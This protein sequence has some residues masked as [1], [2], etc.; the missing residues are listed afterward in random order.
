MKEIILIV[1]RVR[2]MHNVGSFF[3]VADGAGVNEIALCGYTPTPP[4]Q[5]IEKVSL[6][7]ELAVSWKYFVNVIEAVRYYKKLGFQIIVVEKMDGAKIFTDIKYS[8][9]V[10]LIVGHEIDGIDPELPSCADEIAYIPMKGVKESLNVSVA[11]GIVV[12]HVA[13]LGQN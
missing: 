5:Q 1:D 9:R 6:G 13:L 11:A 12:Y 4:R 8:N 2:S 3:R 7:A 10:A